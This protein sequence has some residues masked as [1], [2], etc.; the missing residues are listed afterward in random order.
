VACWGTAVLVQKWVGVQNFSGL[1][2][3]VVLSILVAAVV[4]VVVSLLLKSEEMRALRNLISRFLRRSQDEL[5][6][7]QREA[8][9][10]DSIM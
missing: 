8:V 1:L 3:Q 2:L 6:P 7:Q 5:D 4:Y 10:E 9:D